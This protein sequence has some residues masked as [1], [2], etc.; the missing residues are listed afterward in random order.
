MARE[1]RKGTDLIKSTA[2]NR[3][4]KRK[5]T[6]N[7]Y[8]KPG[9]VRT[10]A[11]VTAADEIPKVRLHQMV[12]IPDDRL[13]SGVRYETFLCKKDPSMV[14][15]SG[16]VCP[17]CD[18]VEHEPTERFI[19]LA[20]EL[21]AEKEGKRVKSLKVKYDTV[22]R[23]DGTE[24]EYPRWGIVIQGAKNFFSYFAAYDEM[25]GDIRDT[26]WEITREGDGVGT[27]YH[28]FEVKAALPDLS[29]VIDN[30][31]TL[32]TL[33]EEMASDE[34]Y[35]TAS[36]LEPGSQPSFGPRKTQDTGTV[37]AGDRAS[38]FAKIKGEVVGSY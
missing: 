5:F 35:A 16:G 11:W 1:F 26:A 28:S 24:V 8:W 9:D 25:S 27:K 18:D 20:V 4:G 17:L 38:E 12:R 10:I 3:G 37:P 15:E 2:E 34:K 29:E 21:E 6:K 19:A 23:D 32:E 7:I 36:E 31:P 30:I 13:E 33:L 22:K 14:D